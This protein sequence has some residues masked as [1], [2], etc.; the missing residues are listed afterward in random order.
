MTSRGEWD[1]DI[2]KERRRAW[3]AHT[4]MLVLL[5]FIQVLVVRREAFVLIFLPSSGEKKKKWKIENFK[6]EN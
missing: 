3:I 2:H 1:N 6:T 4:N 5:E